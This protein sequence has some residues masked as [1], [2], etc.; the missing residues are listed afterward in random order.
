MSIFS[1]LKR[2]SNRNSA[3]IAKERLKI[4]VAHE[5]GR[6]EEPNIDFLPKLQNEIVEVIAKYVTI[7]RDQV[8]IDLEQEG[9]AAVLELNITLPEHADAENTE[10]VA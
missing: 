2:R 9:N 3:A 8:R 10:I 6:N 1:L 5:R 7:D 4:I